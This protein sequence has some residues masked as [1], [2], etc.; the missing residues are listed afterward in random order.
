MTI[1]AYNS[2]Q[3]PSFVLE[4]LRK[5]KACQKAAADQATGR[6]TITGVFSK[7]DHW[8]NQRLLQRYVS[9]RPCYIFNLMKR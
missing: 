2:P 4:R 3:P 1:D 9:L 5:S 7:L 8:K 6:R